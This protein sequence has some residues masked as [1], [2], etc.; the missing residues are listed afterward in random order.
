M[1]T[2]GLL[3]IIIME[4]NDKSQLEVSKNNGVIFFHSSS[5]TQGYESLSRC[6]GEPFSHSNVLKRS[7][8]AGIC[9]CLLKE[10]EKLLTYC[11]GSS[12]R[13]SFGLREAGKDRASG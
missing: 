8:E 2:Y 6:V 3:P 7:L 11:L 13:G 9:S 5:W 10:A 1:V 4:Q 12:F